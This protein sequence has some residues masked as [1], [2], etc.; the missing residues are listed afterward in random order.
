MKNRGSEYLRNKAKAIQEERIK[1]REI[2]SYVDKKSG[3]IVHVYEGPKET[4]FR[5][6]PTGY[7]E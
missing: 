1:P 2:N 6:I 7:S 4:P 5:C 3:I